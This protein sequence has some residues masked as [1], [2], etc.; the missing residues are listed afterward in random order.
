MAIFHSAGPDHPCRGRRLTRAGNANQR[1]IGCHPVGRKRRKVGY[2]L[3]QV[4]F[5]LPILA[6]KDVDP[7][8]KACNNMPVGSKI[9]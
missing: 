3:D 1:R 6:Q 5:A 8:G 9:V 2:G 4:S 7:T